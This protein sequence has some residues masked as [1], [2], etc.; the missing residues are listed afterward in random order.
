MIGDRPAGLAVVARS[1]ARNPII[2]A[3][4]PGIALNATG[5]GLHPLAVDGLEL[6]APAALALGLLA[7][8]ARLRFAAVRAGC[9]ALLLANDRKSVV[10]GKSVSVRVVLGGPRSLK[11]KQTDA[12][13]NK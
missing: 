4:L 3:C 12:H 9:P 6:L 8:G 2:L 10:Y 7:V 11:N 1:M 13:G 5:I